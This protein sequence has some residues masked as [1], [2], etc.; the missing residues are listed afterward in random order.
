M[1]DGNPI[2]LID[3]SLD[4]S[5]EQLAEQVKQAVASVGFLHLKGTRITQ[6]QVNRMFEIV[7]PFDG[8]RA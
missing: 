1:L 3:L 4:L 2:P 5:D 6:G 7:S 8:S